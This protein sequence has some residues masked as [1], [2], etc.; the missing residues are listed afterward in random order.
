MFFNVQMEGEGV[1]AV[2]RKRKG[3]RLVNPTAIASAKAIE[4]HVSSSA[5]AAPAS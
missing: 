1:R 2:L 3:C 5:R 4:G